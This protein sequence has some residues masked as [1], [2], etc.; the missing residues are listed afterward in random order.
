MFLFLLVLIV[1]SK[2]ASLLAQFA[3]SG[4]SQTEVIN[5]TSKSMS[6]LGP[7]FSL[8]SIVCSLV[9]SVGMLSGVHHLEVYVYMHVIHCELCGNHDFYPASLSLVLDLLRRGDE[10][11]MPFWGE[12]FQI[13]AS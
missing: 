3:L 12:R 6:L 13:T 11:G 7:S 10:N 2:K 1:N 8:D 9:I 4:C 5:N